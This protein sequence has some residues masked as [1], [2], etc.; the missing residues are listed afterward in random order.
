M[1]FS[2]AGRLKIGT[3]SVAEAGVANPAVPS[4]AKPFADYKWRW[5][6]FQPTESLN[7]PA[8][9]LGVLRAM[10]KYEGKSANDPNLSAEFKTVE[11]DAKD[12]GISV[13][14]LAREPTRNLLRNSQQYWKALGV[15][16]TTV[17]A[18][19]LTPLGQKLADGNFTKEEFAAATVLSLELPNSAVENQATVDE[20]KKANLQIKPLQLLL[21]ILLDLFNVAQDQAY[22]TSEEVYR[23]VIPL[24]VAIQDPKVLAG[25][26]AAFRSSPNSYA[27][28]PNCVPRDNDAR[29]VREFLLFLANYDFVTRIGGANNRRDKFVLSP[30]Q[31]VQVADVLELKVASQDLTAVT[32]E[33][34]AADAI[35]SVEREKRLAK[36]TQ[37]P[38]QAK[39][40]RDVLGKCGGKCVISGETLPEV[41]KACHIIEV[42]DKGSDQP[43]NGLCLRSDLHDLL[44]SSH[45]RIGPDGAL[46]LSDKARSSPGYKDLPEKIDVPDH[47]SKE[48][49]GKRFNYT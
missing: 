38:A 9:F 17:P 36:V 14:D 6:T 46:V 18:I 3:S 19:S 8:I 45:L 47:I 7:R 4:V 43:S 33:V 24:V 34:S 27:S 12:S 1:L 21:R 39:F 16:E 26:I 2:S 44:D 32:K 37:R 10:R 23:V 22:L 48:A 11:K 15:L 31:A 29:M 35:V 30:E 5:A 40:R 49:L 42:K 28:L 41:L 25:H 13:P 20:W